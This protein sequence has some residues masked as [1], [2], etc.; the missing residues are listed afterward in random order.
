MITSKVSKANS[1]ECSAWENLVKDF[2]QG[3]NNQNIY[4]NHTKLLSSTSHFANTY[5]KPSLGLH[6][7]NS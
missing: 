2:N 6:R 7:D 1:S 4:D 3:L 5:L